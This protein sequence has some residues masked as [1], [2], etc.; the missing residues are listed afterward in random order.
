MTS[1][2]SLWLCALL[3]L[4]SVTWCE[5]QTVPT[6][7]YLGK[8]NYVMMTTYVGLSNHPQS[9][10]N[11]EEF[12]TSNYGLKI[13]RNQNVTFNKQYELCLG[14]VLKN[15][16]SLELKVGWMST[17]MDFNDNFWRYKD[18]RRLVSAI[19]SPQITGSLVGVNS[20][21]YFTDL[22][23]LAPIGFFIAG[24]LEYAK[25]AYDHDE[26]DF[27]Y[28]D[29]S[30]SDWC[31][32][33]KYHGFTK[34]RTTTNQ[35]TAFN[36]EFCLG[37]SRVI[38]D[39]IL[40]EFGSSVAGSIPISNKGYKLEDDTYSNLVLLSPMYKRVKGFSFVR[41]FFSIGYCF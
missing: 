26:V 3:I 16:L 35:Q 11:P 9:A 4:L 7:G 38:K 39:K 31:R 27:G 23:A 17:S 29:A 28:C 14:R 13:S 36:A 2:V 18:Q 40:V 10:I 37:A 30:S 41:G 1:K 15:Y 12:P 6:S 25:Y 5:A 32:E 19:G 33:P 24:Q 34:V 8:R 22:G 21:F 20:K